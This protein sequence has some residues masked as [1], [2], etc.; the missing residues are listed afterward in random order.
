MAEEALGAAKIAMN[1][2]NMLFEEIDDMYFYL[3][4]QNKYA[5][6]LNYDQ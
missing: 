3:R 4:D 6:K 5:E 1:E 2:R